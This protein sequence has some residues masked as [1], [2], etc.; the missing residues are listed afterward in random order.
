MRNTIPSV[1]KFPYLNFWFANKKKGILIRLGI[2][3]KCYLEP[4]N[5]ISSGYFEK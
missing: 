4:H 1:N 5:S 2:K 3:Q